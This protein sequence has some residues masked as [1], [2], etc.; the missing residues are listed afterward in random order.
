L[1]EVQVAV[2]VWLSIGC[3]NCSGICRTPHGISVGLY[4]LLSLLR[5]VAYSL[6]SSAG[7]RC[8]GPCVLK[9]GSTE[10]SVAM[11]SCFLAFW[12]THLCVCFVAP[13]CCPSVC[14]STQQGSLSVHGAL[15]ILGLFVGSP[16]RCS[17]LLLRVTTL[18]SAGRTT[19]TVA[20]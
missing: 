3:L 13:H 11:W 14:V 4:P 10:K 7:L 20:D 8:C 15:H 18:P 17:V 16:G 12:Y 2:V 19:T 9:V 6:T 1:N 5:K